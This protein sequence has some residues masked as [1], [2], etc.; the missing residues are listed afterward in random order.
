MSRAKKGKGNRRARRESGWQLTL[1]DWRPRPYTRMLDIDRDWDPDLDWPR[2]P[3]VP[4][5]VDFNWVTERIA[6]GGGIWTDADVDR[7]E[8]AGVTH[9]VTAADELVAT[10]SALL[11]GRMAHL[12]NGT[13]D[14]GLLKPTV[15]FANTVAFTQ[16]ALKDPATKVYL[17]C[18]SGKNRGPT[19]AYVALRAAGYNRVAAERLI[20]QARPSVRLLYRPDADAALARMGIA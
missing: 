11:E 20:R 14:D 5:P 3:V 10:T 4:P 2:R 9:V 15:W 6:T 8:R 13:R 12:A 19:S 16:A 7:L 18:W 17:H 1:S